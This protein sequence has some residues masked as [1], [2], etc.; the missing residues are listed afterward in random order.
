WFP[1]IELHHY[2]FRAA[3]PTAQ[4]LVAG[5][6]MHAGFVAPLSTAGRP[7]VTLDKRE[8]R[9]EVDGQLVEVGNLCTFPGGPLGSVRWLAAS[10]ARTGK[11]LEA[12]SIVLTGS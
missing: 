6:A 10:L 3:K 4:E 11:R 9:I 5:N 12:G 7:V 8:L 2:L 1:V